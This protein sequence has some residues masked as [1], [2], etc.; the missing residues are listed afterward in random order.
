MAKKQIVKIG[1]ELGEFDIIT[2]QSNIKNL[3]KGV[4]VMAKRRGYRWVRIRGKGKRC[5]SPSGRFAPSYM[6]G[7][8][9]R[10][11]RRGRRRYRDYGYDDYGYDD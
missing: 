4:K 11:T 9:R 3:E 7:G 6:C 2:L 8:S 1:K 5:K 10:R